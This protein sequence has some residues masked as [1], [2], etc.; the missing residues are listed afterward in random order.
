[1]VVLWRT[2]RVIVVKAQQVYFVRRLVILRKL[3]TSNPAGIDW[4]NNHLAN[5]DSI[6][7]PETIGFPEDSLWTDI[8]YHYARHRIVGLDVVEVHEGIA[9]IRRVDWPRR[10][11]VFVRIS[12]FRDFAAVIRPCVRRKQGLSLLCLYLCKPILNRAISDTPG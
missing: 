5:L 1:M 4:E 2:L 9:F 6:V 11:L 10:G 7:W 12:S 3:L 8:L